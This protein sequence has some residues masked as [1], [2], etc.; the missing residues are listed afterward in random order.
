MKTNNCGSGDSGGYGD[1]GGFGVIG[2]TG[3]ALR[4]AHRS[5]GGRSAGVATMPDPC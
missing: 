4:Q 1:L 3:M 2:I 5:S